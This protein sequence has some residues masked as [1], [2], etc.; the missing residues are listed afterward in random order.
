[1]NDSATPMRPPNASAQMWYL[2]TACMAHMWGMGTVFAFA[3]AWMKD[4]Q[5]GETFIGLVVSLVQGLIFVSGFL[6]G[7]LADRTRQVQR[8]ALIGTAAMA[9]AL[10][11]F[12]FSRTESD[13]IV[14]AILRGLS[15]GMILNMMPL[16]VIAMTG[17][18]SQGQAY[19]RYR[20][21]GSIGFLLGAMGLPVVLEALG[22][23]DDLQ[24]I[25]LCAAAGMLLGVLPLSR[26]KIE[27][28]GRESGSAGLGDLLRDPEVIL[29]LIAAFFFALANPA[30]YNFFAAYGRVLG[31]DNE[32]LA[33]LTGLLGVL[34]ILGLPVAGWVCDRFGPRWMLFLAFLCQPFR[35]WSLSVVNAYEW[36]WIPQVFHFFTWAGLEVAALLF[37][38][39]IAGEG[40]RGVAVGAYSGMIVLGWTTGGIIAGYLAEHH[41]YVFMFR[42]MGGCAATACLAFVAGLL[43]R[44]FAKKTRPTV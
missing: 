3:S 28:P 32:A 9:V 13:F 43:Y 44:R 31:A 26:V 35:A 24:L 20:I 33:W 1:M 2:R 40:R 19:G 39:R 10:A 8:I 41:G 42:V 16:L 11:L 36:L 7:Y 21:F 12:G 38:T 30:V 37:I 25:I 6:W 17:G 23:G 34:A 18:D 5:M 29:F 15:Q 4:L 27:T 14:Y 22:H